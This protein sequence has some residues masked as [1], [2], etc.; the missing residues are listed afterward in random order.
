MTRRPP[1]WLIFSVTANGSRKG[2]PEADLLIA[3]GTTGRVAT[4]RH[5]D[6]M[7]SD[8]PGSQDGAAF[9]RASDGLAITL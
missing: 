7:S 8:M 3:E 4:T 2:R 5:P 9:E 6:Q 1:A